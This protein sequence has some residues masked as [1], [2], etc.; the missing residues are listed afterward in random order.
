MTK[1][2]IGILTEDELGLTAL[3][4]CFYGQ[5]SEGNPVFGE[6]PKLLC[7]RTGEMQ[8]LTGRASMTV[9]SQMTG[10]AN[11]CK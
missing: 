4:E 2:D 7:P 3:M 11:D 10:F 5:Y 6:C 9:L 8:V 1:V